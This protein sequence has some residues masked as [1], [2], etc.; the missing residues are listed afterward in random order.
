MA[1]IVV[2]GAGIAGL[3]TAMLLAGDGHEV[4]V[5]ERDPS[6]PPAPGEAARG[7]W[8][9]RGVNQFRL[10]HLLLCRFRQICDAE[11]PGAARAI[12]ATGGI[13]MDGLDYIQGPPDRPRHPRQ[14]GDDDFV[15]LTVCRP[16]VE[17]AMA[18][19]AESTPKVEVRR[20]T[21]VRGLLTGP[22]ARRGIPT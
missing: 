1:H 18:Q 2:L 5:L 21:A 16:V 17:A 11:L 22:S 6:P 8:E 14:P 19:V 12:E 4:T 13:W 3:G 20:G 9:R 7:S 15:M 10:P